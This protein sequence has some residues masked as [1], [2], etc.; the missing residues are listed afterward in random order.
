MN[1]M[2]NV[3]EYA[4]HVGASK[5]TVMRR[6]TQPG[7]IAGAVKYRTGWMIPDSSPLPPPP[8][9]DMTVLKASGTSMGSA[10]QLSTG[11]AEPPPFSLA[12]ALDLEP[13]LLDVERAAYLIGCTEYAIRRHPERFDAVPYGPNGAWMIPQATVRQLAG[14]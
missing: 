4:A 11:A 3:D 2:M 1:Q 7:G 10:V 14:L 13:A 5:R 6:L 12:Q 8:G 9:L